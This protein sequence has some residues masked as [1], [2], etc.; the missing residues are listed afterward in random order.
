M[1]IVTNTAQ[2]MPASGHLRVNLCKNKRFGIVTIS[3]TG[4]GIP[5]EHVGRIFDPFFTTKDVGDGFGLGLS[6]TYEIIH[7]R[8]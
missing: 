4:P 6:I 5:A 3:D 7:R 1:N 2:A 8:G